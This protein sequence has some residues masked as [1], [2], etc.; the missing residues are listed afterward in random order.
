MEAKWRAVAVILRRAS[1]DEDEAIVLGNGDQT[2]WEQ[3]DEVLRKWAR[4]APK[5]KYHKC[6]YKIT[7]QDG[8]IH[9]GRYNLRRHDMNF[10][11][12]LGRHVFRYAQFHAGLFRGDLS[13]EQYLQFLQQDF[14]REN[15]KEF[16]K[17]LNEYEIPL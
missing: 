2:V 10:K 16:R 11:S 13:E 6:R 8:K 4:S 3:A 7:Y 5:S 14:V 15:I 12:L 1:N 9:E 17:L